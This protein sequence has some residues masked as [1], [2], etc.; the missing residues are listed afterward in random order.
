[1]TDR[2]P[3][4]DA[5]D[6]RVQSALKDYLERQDRGESVDRERFLTEHA[7]IADELRSF[8]AAD[9][10]LAGLKSATP[11]PQRDVTTHSVAE[12]GME[13]V[14]PQRVQEAERAAD[15]R[16][17]PPQF[18]RYTVVKPLGSGAM[19]TVYLAEDSQLQ[20]KVALKT[21]S[22]EDDPHGE[23]LERF[24]R[25]ARSAATLRN[26]HICPVYDVGE[27]D[28]RHYISMAY[29]QGRPLSAYI[30]PDKPQ[31]ERNILLLIRKM[32]LALQEAHDHGIIHRDLKPGNVMVDEKGEPII[33]DFGLARKVQKDAES[34][35][36]HSGMIVGSPAYMSPEQ[37]EGDGDKLTPA[38]DQYSLG[39]ILYELLTG[40]LPFR[41]G[42]TAV[43]GA[44]LTKAPPPVEQ[45]RKDVSPR[46][47]ALCAR[48]MHK[49][50][51]QR[52]PSCKAVADEIASTLRDEKLTAAPV[53]PL[54]TRGATASAM[55]GAQPATKPPS[56][57]S[58]A[59]P[60]A[61]APVAAAASVTQSNVTSLYEAAQKCMRKHDYEQVV[62]MLDSIPQQKRTDEVNALLTKARGLADEVAFLL[63][64]IDEALRLNDNET[65][66]RKADELLKLKP[67]HH[68]ALQLKEELGRYG[69][70]RIWKAG[71]YTPDGRRIG[72]GSWIPWIG[73]AVGVAAF[74]LALW[75][76]TIY[77]KAGDAVVRIQ[78]NDPDVEVSFQGRTLNVQSA[79]Q[80]LEVEP[81]DETLKIRYGDA[82][83][84][85]QAFT[86]NKGDNPAVVI[87]I[88]DDTLAAKFGELDIGQWPVETQVDSST[89]TP[90]PSLPS[91][92]SGWSDL[93][94]NGIDE[95]R[96]HTERWTYA[97]GVLTGSANAGAGNT[98]LFSPRPYDD[99]ELR[100]QFRIGD[101]INTGVQVR[102]EIANPDQW[103]ARGPQCDIGLR[104]GDYTGGVWGEPGDG[105]LLQPGSPAAVKPDEWNDYFVR[106][107][108][109]QIRI[110]VNG[111]NT[112]D[113]EVPQ[114][115]A[116]GLLA[117]QIH[118]R[119]TSKVEFR[120]IEVRE[121]HD[122]ATATATADDGWT[123]LFNG[124]D[125]TGWQGLVGDPVKRSQMSAA[126]L[127]AAQTVADQNMRK[128]WSV[129]DGVLEFDGKGENLCSVRDF[130]DFELMLDWKIPPGGDSGVYLRG[131]PQVQIWD[132]GSGKPDADK[133]SG[134]LFNNRSHPR[135]PTSKA[136]R[137]VGEWNTLF[138]RMVGD[139]VT[140]ELNGTRVVDN[141]VMENYFARNEPV[142]P[143]GPIELQK[144][145]GRL[146]F[147]NIRIRELSSQQQAADSPTLDDWTDLFNGRDLTGWKQIGAGGWTV[148]NGVLTSKPGEGW[149]ATEQEFDDFE[150]QLDFRLSQGANSGVFLR[151]PDS[152]APSG[153]D[154][155]EV[156]LIDD[157]LQP[158]VPAWQQTGAIYAV[159]GPNPPPNPTV[160]QW[161]QLTVHADG[162]EITVSIDGREVNRVNVETA[163]VVGPA[164][165]DLKRPSGHIGF[166]SRN[167]PVEFRN[168]RIRETG[169]GQV[170]LSSAKAA[171]QGQWRAVAQEIAGGV[172]SAEQIAEHDKSIT[173][174]NDS[175]HISYLDRGG[176]VQFE[177]GTYQLDPSQQP[178]HITMTG[179]N[180]DGAAIEFVGIYQVVGEELRHC[181]VK[182]SGSAP[183]AR[184][185]SFSTSPGS[186]QFSTTY[187]RESSSSVA[188][189]GAG[190]TDLFNGR[191]LTG[192][193]KTGVESGWSVQNGEI[194]AAGGAQGGNAG[195]LMTEKDY[196]D[197]ELQLE[198]AVSASTDSGVG[199][200][201]DPQQ[202]GP[203]ATNQAEIQIVDEQ[204]PESVQV[205]DEVPH[206]RTGALAALSSAATLP[207]LQRD[208]W[209]T[210]TVHLQGRRLQVTI[211]GLLTV[212]TDLD[213]HVGKAR[214]A[215]RCGVWRADGPI[216]LQKMRG[217]A[218]FRN[219]RIRELMPTAPTAAFAPGLAIPFPENAR[220]TDARP[221]SE[222]NES[223][224]IHAYPWISPDGLTIYWTLEG[225]NAPPVIRQATRNNTAAPFGAVRDVLQGGR[226]AT[227]SPDGLELV[228]LADADGDGKLDELC[229]SRRTGNDQPFA[230][231]EPIP[232]MESASS[233]KGS[234][235]SP[236]GLSLYALDSAPT[237][238]NQPS[239]VLVMRR[240]DESAP[241][242]APEPVV[243][244]GQLPSDHWLTYPSL[245][246]SGQ[247]ML[248][249][250][251]NPGDRPHEYG[252]VADATDDPLKFANA[253]PLML[254]GQPFITRGARYCAATGELFYT[255]P[256]GAPPF[257]EME[258][259]TA[260][261]ASSTQQ[262]W[263]RN[264]WIS[265]DP[266]RGTASWKWGEPRGNGESRTWED[267]VLELNNSA[268]AF[269]SVQA[270]DVSFKAQVQ[271]FPQGNHVALIVRGERGKGGIHALLDTT[272]DGR[273]YV[274][275][276]NT[277]SFK[278][279]PRKQGFVEF[280]VTAIGDQVTISLDGETVVTHT[281][282]NILRKG[283]L[284]LSAVDARGR[285]KDIQVKILDE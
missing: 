141:V 91:G 47:A 193:Q 116:T 208:E 57:R 139:R 219:I 230:T 160:G 4:T 268:I 107:T 265:L 264:Q 27:I 172:W 95:W 62:Q 226:I 29:I 218:R 23:L 134:G 224:A 237:A 236:D 239:Q 127:A 54:A 140:V 98:F 12:R 179:T 92:E 86:L 267:G 20:R 154:F 197:F 191:D 189:D 138:I 150:L 171:L 244:E 246:S 142:Y 120:N 228:C 185:T 79:N 2:K 96:G 128:H 167:Q 184:P 123:E 222:L 60:A 157:S 18:G 192:W 31:P 56:R 68:R 207:S 43:I 204:D 41:G 151:I 173:F 177:R 67:R 119:N 100:F 143:T 81:G 50:A 14:I 200:R 180:R 122:P 90:A 72:E 85:T 113:G 263:P 181:F 131:C 74:G 102:S 186:G 178:P 260:R 34:R 262:T 241:W 146:W 132:T 231:P 28:G 73:I 17:L 7:D 276:L 32:A 99:F 121:L 25:E 133:G 48:M 106:C 84:E 161:H 183:A 88:L 80:E 281:E 196:T 105:W 117:F 24:Y 164:K 33:M 223:G 78:I 234:A 65:L 144:F 75:A 271:F 169:R 229:S 82:E 36:T 44:I 220:F 21:P 275:L 101:E 124:R 247:H 114:M 51:G 284:E 190:W 58:S 89:T 35:L 233:P 238:A 272:D 8:L 136:D 83:F 270:R 46:V 253:R 30:Q 13:T 77:L 269:N 279:L 251:S 162:P 152:G 63:A 187:R 115:A 194:V 213:Q 175:F 168:I 104:S 94:A 59:T 9:A 214:E 64:E 227:V 6:P 203:V 137:P 285:F 252:A 256:L 93:F 159:Q 156:Q 170:D 259:Y 249:S 282:L 266:E 209:K 217:T 149:I 211:D 280:M 40:R 206:R 198:F 76:V 274:G 45:V 108:G 283:H 232:S 71:G 125:L 129:V 195:W 15:K 250:Y 210:M 39:V 215:G 166:Q 110:D 70:G 52:F 87:A 112:V 225:G 248:L 243:I 221:L 135:L 26:P 109:R 42:I 174:T 240:A 69:K 245:E 165:R 55:P 145:T 3:N 153:G 261:V 255:K 205:L 49:Q 277:K 155:M 182:A 258:L 202:P 273:T 212:D 111:T 66:G 16:S 130:G 216:A 10:Q 242:G 126:E 97:N 148:Q 188:E 5:H 201:C 37:V 235:F 103:S 11:A 118:S 163:P 1:M 147:R 254:D 176:R 199:F 19:G 158:N 53:P 278:V 38:A 61:A 257:R 22:F